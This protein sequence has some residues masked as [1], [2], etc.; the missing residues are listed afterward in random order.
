ML[1]APQNKSSFFAQAALL[2]GM[3]VASSMAVATPQN[4]EEAKG[5]RYETWTGFYGGVSLGA[6]W[7]GST[8]H[9]QHVNLTPSSGSYAFPLDATAV[10]PGFQLGYLDHLS[11]HWVLGIEADFTYPA[12]NASRTSKTACCA[13]DR[14]R[15]RD[16]LQGSLRLR[17]GYAAGDFLG[18]V[19]S[20]AS[21]GSLG[22]YYQNESGNAYNV[23]TAQTGW[24]LGGGVEYLFLKNL[25]GRVEYLFTDYGN[26]L[27][28]QAPIISS[29]FDPFGAVHGSMNNN[30]LRAGVNYWF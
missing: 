22:M 2:I 4:P 3:V 9:A 29:V 17:A 15:V 21:W 11:E 23:R 25:S 18:Y 16:N 7:A 1:N 27:N 28:M 8:I 19:T 30:V 12:T 6:L 26:A 14:F 20:G 5:T 10:D 13:F 24:V